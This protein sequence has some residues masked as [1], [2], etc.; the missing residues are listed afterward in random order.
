MD[1]TTKPCREPWAPE[2]VVKAR[3]KSEVD[4]LEDWAMVWPGIRLGAWVVCLHGHGSTGDQIFTRQDIRDAWLPQF[5]KLGLGVLSPNLRGDAWMSP[6]AVEDL[7]RLIQWTRGEYAADRFIFPSGSMGGTGNLIYAV[8]RPEDVDVVL[9]RCPAT[10]L[11][12]YH[13]WL[14]QNDGGVRDEICRAIESAYG[15]TPEEAPETYAAHSV[16][17]NAHR[18]T[19]PLLLIH[20][21]ADALIPV[22]QS[23]DLAAVLGAAPGFQYVEM[24]GGG[25][26]APLH[27]PGA[28]T[29]LQRHASL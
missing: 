3:Y 28:E 22:E 10:D 15:G 7:H 29:W 6:P 12:S 19:M 1:L 16:M 26:D 8:R 14:L 9:A 4:G 23:R 13:A 11:A 21:D 17:G 2:G 5:R 27:W 25:H 24:P 18:L 20:G